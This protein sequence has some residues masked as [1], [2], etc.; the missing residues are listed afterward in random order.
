MRSADQKVC[1]TGG[2]QGNRVAVAR[3]DPDPTIGSCTHMR[4]FRW[5]CFAAGE[6]GEL[7]N[8]NQVS[9][10]SAHISLGFAGRQGTGDTGS[11]H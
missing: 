2:A 10:P 4:R 7:P 9:Y 5:C 8:K 3:L 6:A 1:V 11:G